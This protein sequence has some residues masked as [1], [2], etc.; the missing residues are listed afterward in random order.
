[1]SAPSFL[2]AGLTV[3]CL[4]GG[5]FRSLHLLSTYLCSL[6]HTPYSFHDDLKSSGANSLTWWVTRAI[7]CPSEGSS[8]QDHILSEHLLCT[9]DSPCTQDRLLCLYAIKEGTH[10][11]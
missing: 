5:F 1:M 9:T 7:L 2:A 6:P 8:R 4:R 3:T 10:I 11:Y